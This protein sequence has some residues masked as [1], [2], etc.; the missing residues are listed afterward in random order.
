MV[1]KTILSVKN[2]VKIYRNGKVKTEAVKGISFDIKEG[3][4]VALSGPSDIPSN[5]LTG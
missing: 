5:F 1:K 2:L 4:F 3:E